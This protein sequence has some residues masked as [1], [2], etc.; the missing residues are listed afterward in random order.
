V[1]RINFGQ[2]RGHPDRLRN[3]NKQPEMGKRI[4]DVIAAGGDIEIA[5]HNELTR[6]TIRSV[7]PSEA[8]HKAANSGLGIAP[9]L[10]QPTLL[11]KDNH[12]VTPAVHERSLGK[13]EFRLR[14]GLGPTA[15]SKFVKNRLSLRPFA[16]LPF[17]V[18]DRTEVG[19][20]SGG[21]SPSV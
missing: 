10:M 1:L 4:H 16:A 6:V 19:W 9:P 15:P 17:E 18:R 7:R 13:Q 3:V 2:R 14:A 5:A 20:N 11:A 21:A 8:L 12:H